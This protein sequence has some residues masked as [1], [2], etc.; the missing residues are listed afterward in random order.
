MVDTM[1]DPRWQRTYGT[2]GEDPEFIAD[3]AERLVVGFQG[4]SEGVQ[5][6]G[7][8]LTIKHFPGGGARENG[9]DPHYK[10]GQWNVYQTED[11]LQR[12]HLPGF[13][14]AVDNNVSSIMPYYAKPAPGK[15]ASL[16]MTITAMS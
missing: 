2:F 8:A 11:S 14:A 16:S 5:S 10:Q 12:Y 13:K 15:R 6:D 3:A 1:T 9:F 4:S 7:I